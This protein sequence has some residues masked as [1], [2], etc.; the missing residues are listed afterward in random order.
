MSGK[1]V[2]GEADICEILFTTDE[3]AAQVA[4]LGAEITAHYRKA[5]ERGERLLVVSVL[6]GSVVFLSDLIR[7]IQLPLQLSFLQVSSYGNATASS[8]VVEVR[9]APDRRLLRG[10]HVLV[11]EDILDTGNTLFKVLGLLSDKG[12]ASVKLC[13]FLDKPSRRQAKVEAD[14]CGAQIPDRFAVGYGLDFAE[15]YRNLPYIGILKPEI[16]EGIHDPE[17]V[18]I[19]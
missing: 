15:N 9:L 7:A 12:A 18:S 14:F 13:A 6:K 16:Y 4:R 11:V 17:G 19:P 10:A 2:P 1:S 5:A 3:I 8:G